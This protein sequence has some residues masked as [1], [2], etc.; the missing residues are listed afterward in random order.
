MAD[1]KMEV[2]EGTKEIPLPFDIDKPIASPGHKARKVS[3]LQSGADK[4]HNGIF[5]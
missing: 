3:D 5:K 2:G 1:T 4:L